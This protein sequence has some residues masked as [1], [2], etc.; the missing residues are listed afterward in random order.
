VK[1]WKSQLS[2]WKSQHPDE[3]NSYKKWVTGH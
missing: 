2:Q 3:Y 1:L